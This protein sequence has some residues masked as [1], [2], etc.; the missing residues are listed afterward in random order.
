MRATGQ[1]TRTTLSVAVF[2]AALGAGLG[3]GVGPGCTH[4]VPDPHAKITVQPTPPHAVTAREPG[5]MRVVVTIAPL[6]G[7]VREL[8]PPNCTVTTLIAP[9]QSEHGY[10]FTPEDLAALARADLVVYNGLGLEAKVDRFVRECPSAARVDFC[11]AG[12]LGLAQP[13]GA[14]PHGAGH[15]ADD[16]DDDHGPVDVHVWLDPALVRAIVPKLAAAL[17]RAGDLPGVP[18]TGAS[19]SVD[20]VL[21][22]I[23]ELDREYRRRLTPLAGRAIVTHHNAWSRLASRYGLRVAAVIRPVESSEPTPGQ[24]AACVHAIREQGVR[25][26]FVE[27]QFDGSAAR[28]VAASA[29]VEVRVLDPLGDGDWFKVM[30]ANLDALAGGLAP[31]A[32][33]TLRTT[34]GG[35]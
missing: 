8:A 5:P 31:A 22:R 12:E 34:P 4:R 28:H 1:R 25:T 20:A 30:Y 10:E 23:D 6:A 32:A 3:W 17:D 29:G 2:V 26:I 18:P 11:A 21:A 35:S 9:G 7:L 24:I 14:M 19:P 27:P 16:D 13:E 33:G 15:H